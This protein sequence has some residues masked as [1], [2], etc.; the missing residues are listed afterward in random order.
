MSSPDTTGECMCWC[1][2]QGRIFVNGTEEG[3]V[4]PAISLG[5]HG[6]RGF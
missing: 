1:L 4:K 5:N 3:R 2:S 6:S